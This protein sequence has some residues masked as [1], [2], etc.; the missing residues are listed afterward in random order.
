MHHKIAES[1]IKN[2][3]TVSVYEKYAKNSLALLALLYL[4]ISNEDANN[5]NASWIPSTK[6]FKELTNM[7]FMYDVLSREG[8]I[9]F[10]AVGGFIFAARYNHYLDSLEEQEYL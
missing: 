4:A 1:I 5:S 2:R 6:P 9:L 10:I 8:V 3:D 7:T